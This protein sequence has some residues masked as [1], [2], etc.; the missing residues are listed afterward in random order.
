MLKARY[1]R[2]LHTDVYFQEAQDFIDS[3]PSPEMLINVTA[4]RNDISRDPGR[5][6]MIVVW[7]W[8]EEEETLETLG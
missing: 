6:D 5:S 3:L 2:F 7:Y 1:R 8:E 4:M